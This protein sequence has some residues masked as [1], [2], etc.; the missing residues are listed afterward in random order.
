MSRILDLR[1]PQFLLLYSTTVLCFIG[2][3]LLLRRVLESG[4]VPRLGTPDPYQIAYLRAGSKEAI[5]VACLSLIDRGL[6]TSDGELLRAAPDAFL[7]ARKRLE[8]D[9]LY[10]CQVLMP[11]RDVL[12]TTGPRNACEEDI[13][14]RLRGVGL[15]P[16]SRQKLRRVLIGLLCLAPLW[17][18]AQA[19]IEVALA[20]GR[21]NYQ[22][23]IALAVLAPLGLGWA[24]YSRARRRS[25]RACW[26]TC[27]R[28]SPA[29]VIELPSSPSAAPAMSSRSSSASSASARSPALHW[30]NGARF[31]RHPRA[32]R[33]RQAR[34]VARR[35]AAPAAP[36]VEGAVVA[37][38]VVAAV[39]AVADGVGDRVGL[40]WRP[41]LAL[42]IL[43]HL[44][45][46]DVIEVIAD[47][48]FAAPKKQLRAMRTL[49]LQVPLVLHGVSLGLASAQ[50]VDERRL[51]AMARVVDALSPSFWSEHLAFVRAAGL[52]LG[53][54]AAPP[55][56]LETIEGTRRN[57]ERAARAVGALPLLEN[58]ATLVDPPGSTLGEVDWV[59]HILNETGGSLLLDLNNL[60]ANAVNFGFDPL[61]F[62]DRMAPRV[63]A[64]HLA[65]GRWV[66][67]GSGRRL[68]DDHHHDVPEAVYR[69]LYELA[70]RVD[71]PL[72]V[73]LERDG[74]FPPFERL[75]H[76]LARARQT[77]VLGRQT[78]ITRP[79]ATPACALPPVPASDGAAA[80]ESYLA[81]LLVDDRARQ[82]FLAD[83][84]GEAER[85]GLDARAVLALVHVDRIGLELAADS[86]AHKRASRRSAGAPRRSRIFDL[87]RALWGVK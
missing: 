44:E 36:P 48:L 86:F 21:H 22:F 39:A 13:A 8:R 41:E 10:A 5:R 28:C 25:E 70:R 37:V 87:G 85:E 63:G 4:P 51:G 15:I 60:Y 18:L 1:G 40:S 26:T 42:G 81:R 71:H 38:A 49:A 84:G 43:A 65:G 33:A 57:V 24:L 61:A 52:E 66:K 67:A 56:T 79:L 74:A 17:W 58:V 54:L 46:I 72:T 83:P 16:T 69:L 50:P 29:F 68:L 76:E 2:L 78:S 12:K 59:T 73:L 14:E 80:F 19:K 32:R 64:V 31:S 53:H 35:A 62:L 23:L 82:R 20:R 45:Q 34:R 9:I 3:A 75:L 7:R 55:R 47:D 77:L 6:L 11:A 27:A 30:P